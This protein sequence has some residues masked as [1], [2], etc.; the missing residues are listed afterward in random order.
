MAPIRIARQH[1]LQKIIE[2][3]NQ[4]VRRGFHT[5]DITPLSLLDRL[6]WFKDHNNTKYPIYVFEKENKVVGW[7]SISP[8]RKGREALRFTAEVSYYI[9]E[10]FQRQG[11]GSELLAHA[12]SQMETLEIKTLF[13]I[14]LDVNDGSI[15][16]LEKFGFQ[17]WA[18]LPNIADFDG[19][20]CGQYYYG[21]QIQQKNQ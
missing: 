6:H 12:I 17:R 3:Y 19:V 2:I 1:D 14:L 8:Y 20:E 13:A 7:L 4:A 10:N 11:I 15:R 16:L 5:A 21:Y 9:D 18:H